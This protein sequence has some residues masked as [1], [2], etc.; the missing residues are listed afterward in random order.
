MRANRCLARLAYTLL[1]LTLFVGCS[2]SDPV[3]NVGDTSPPA[4]TV[5]LQGAVIADKS[6]TLTWTVPGDDGATGQATAYAIRYST[7]PINAANFAAANLCNNLPAP[8]VAGATQTFVV[9]GLSANTTY[10]F[11]LVTADEV[12]NWSALSNIVTATTAAPVP[13]GEVHYD[14]DNF[15][16]VGLSSGGTFIAAARFTNT[17]L[18]AYVGN[19]IS[20]VKVYNYLNSATT[21]TVKVYGTG[22][23][24]TPGATLYSQDLTVQPGWNTLAI[25]PAITI[26]SDDLW[27]GYA[28]THNAGEYP[29][30]YD[31]GPQ[32]PDGDWLSLDD[33]SSWL[34]TDFGNINIRLVITTP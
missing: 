6:V 13:L 8:G 29:A 12:P 28:V 15:T 19:N 20:S 14:G 16:G 1:L 9:T 10:H 31:S 32:V 7:V 26:P 18:G 22:T 11:A 2:G 34:H 17:Q 27:V 24:T 23:A 5:D 30:G 33:G 25:S 4:A 21:F 3:N